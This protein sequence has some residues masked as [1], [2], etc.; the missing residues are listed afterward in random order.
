MTMTA[1]GLLRSELRLAEKKVTALKK[2]LAA[3]EAVETPPSSAASNGVRQR[4]YHGREP[5]S[6]RVALLRMLLEEKPNLTQTQMTNELNWTP[7][8]I[9]HVVARMLDSGE[10]VR[11]G[12]FRSPKATYR[13]ASGDRV[14]NV[15]PGVG[16]SEGRKK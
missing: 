9:S 12:A 11:E 5:M 1:T 13:L 16:V 2:A 7:G 15:E 10:I 3:L 4:D 8:V 14:T 6:E